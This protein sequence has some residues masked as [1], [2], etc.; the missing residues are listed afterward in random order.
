MCSQACACDDD[1]SNARNYSTPPSVRRV[2]RGSAREQ[3]AAARAVPH[4][5][6][7]S[8][9]ECCA[10]AA[11]PE[12][13]RL[14]AARAAA[15]AHCACRH[16]CEAAVGAARAD[17][18]ALRRQ[19]PHAALRCRSP[20]ATD[21]RCRRRRAR[22]GGRARGQA[23]GSRCVLSRAAQRSARPKAHASL[24]PVRRADASIWLVQFIKARGCAARAPVLRL[25]RCLWRRRCVT[26]ARA[27]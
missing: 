5:G 26:T 20:R 14:R 12:A 11:R 24:R 7:V 10:A 25:S 22:G 13:A 18:C 21:A 16:G 17:R 9:R 1:V 3:G 8:L 4:T 6:C 27:R 19:G 15:L 23:R 2:A